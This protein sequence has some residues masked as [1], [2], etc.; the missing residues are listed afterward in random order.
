MKTVY[1]S[2][3][4]SFIIPS[5]TKENKYVRGETKTD[6][7]FKIYEWSKKGYECVYPA[8]RVVNTESI[9]RIGEVVETE[10]FY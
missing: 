2:K 8:R 4:Y 10:G 5:K 3:R 9:H 6:I 1:R 7:G